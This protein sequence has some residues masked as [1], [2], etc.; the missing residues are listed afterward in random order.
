MG[1]WLI[2]AP[3]LVIEIISP[4]NSLPK[5]RD[6][7]QICLQNGCREF[8]IVDLRRR[9]VQV[10]TAAGHSL[11]TSGRRIPLFFGGAV[12]VDEIFGD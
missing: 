6:K 3:E 5:L 4:S 12:A 1:D 10:L 7:A 9:Q 8:W 11:F 2:G